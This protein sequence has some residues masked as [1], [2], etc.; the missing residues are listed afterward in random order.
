MQEKE[1]KS[2]MDHSLFHNLRILGV[3]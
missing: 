3:W 2:M 1:L